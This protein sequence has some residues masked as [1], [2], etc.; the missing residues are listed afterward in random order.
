MDR[1][2]ISKDGV[3]QGAELRVG[4]ERTLERAVQHLYPI[5]LSYDTVTK[6]PEL[7][8]K[9]T[10]LN[11]DVPEFRPKRSAAAVAECRIQDIAEQDS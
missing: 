4:A 8:S 1:L 11:G 5:E 10:Q 3:I 7:R 9:T 6:T 2:I